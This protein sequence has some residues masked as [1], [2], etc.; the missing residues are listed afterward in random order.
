MVSLGAGPPAGPGGS[1]LGVYENGALDPPLLVQGV[2]GKNGGGG[3]AARIGDPGAPAY[4]VPMDLGKA[5]DEPG[6]MLWGLLGKSVVL[7]EDGG[8][9]N[10]ESL[11]SGR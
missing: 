8:I 3:K 7:L 9:G 2:E 10:A 1:G 6:L 5:I 4:P 11:R